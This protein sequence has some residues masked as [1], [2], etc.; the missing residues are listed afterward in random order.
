MK[1][2][3]AHQGN[4]IDSVVVVGDEGVRPFVS[5]SLELAR[6]LPGEIPI[7]AYAACAAADYLADTNNGGHIQYLHNFGWNPLQRE[8]CHFALREAGLERCASTFARFSAHVDRDWLKAAQLASIGSSP[9]GY[10]EF[11]Q[12]DEEECED[13]FSAALPR[14]NEWIRNAVAFE[15][16]ETEGVAVAR[17][18]S[19]LARNR[20]RDRR[21]PLKQGAPTS[22]SEATLL[23][24]AARFEKQVGSRVERL[25]F[26][27]RWELCDFYFGAMPVP[28]W[29]WLCGWRQSD[30]KP[31]T[32]HL[33]LLPSGI[34]GG[35]KVAMFVDR[36]RTGRPLG[37]LDLDDDEFRM[38]S[39]TRPPSTM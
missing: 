12:Y 9:A 32:S 29:G 17:R 4:L 3:V 18:A 30:G 24:L 25:F 28:V 20:E 27:S 5:W 21:L 6:F 10:E 38:A 19:L 11:G 1:V 34:F 31:R 7:T 35:P 15:N 36:D 39:Q 2:G 26:G 14:L 8:C 16:V 13:I 23:R 33:L 37:L 22:V